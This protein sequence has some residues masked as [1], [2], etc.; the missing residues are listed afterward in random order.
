MKKHFLFAFAAIT[1]LLMTACSEDDIVKGQ[2]GNT[3]TF[4]VGVPQLTTRA[5]GEGDS[6]NKLYWGVYDH[7]NVLLTEI[8]NT[9][10]GQDFFQKGTVHLTLA[11]DK[12]YSIVFW[13][14]NE[15]N[16]MCSVDWNARKMS[17]EPQFANQESYDAF[18][19][20]VEIDNVSGY[21]KRDVTLY[22]P[23]AQ[24]NIG[25]ADVEKAKK[26][27]LTVKNTKVRISGLPKTYDF[28]TGNTDE[29]E[30]TFTY[31]CPKE[32]VSFEGE[33]F[34]VDGYEYLAMNYALL[35]ADKQLVE[36]TFSY[37]D[38]DNQQHNRTY[39]SVP[40]Q[41][42]WRTNI[43]GNILTSE[44]DFE[45]TIE[46]EFN[47]ESHNVEIVEVATAESLQETINEM[48]DGDSITIV[49]TDNIDLSDLFSSNNAP[50]KTRGG[51]AKSNSVT[52]AKGRTLELD[53]NGFTISGTDETE[54]NYGLIQNNGTLTI[55]DSKGKGRLFVE[56]TVNS[57]WNRYSA[58]ISNNPGATLTVN[59]GTIEHRG[60]T[61]MAY[62][63]DN[64]TNGNLG[65]VNCTINGGTI[66]STYRAV[67]QFLN[68]DSD[69]NNLVINGGVLTG[70][71]KSIFFQDPSAKA[72]NGKLIVGKNAKL[73]G[74]V[75]LYV[76]AGSTAWPVEVSIAKAAL[77]GESTVLSANVPYDYS[78]VE[79]DDAWT[80]ESYFTFGAFV[81][82]VV[83]AKGNFNGKGIEVRIK[84]ASGQTDN[85]NSCLVPNRLQK[86]SNPEVYYAQ[87]QRFAELTNISITNVNFV[88][89]PEEITVKDAWNPNGATT[90]KE[91][92]NGELQFMNQGN[93]TLAN[94]TF[95]KV[96]V[97]PINASAVTVCN[98]T[99]NGLQA[100]AIKDIKASEVNVI[101]NTFTDCNG[102]FWLA[103][104]PAKLVVTGNTFTGVGR[105]GAMQFSAN[106]DYTKTEMTVKDNTVE[107]AFLWQLN[108]T[109]SYAQLNAILNKDLN[110][111]TQDYTDNSIKHIAKVG[112]VGYF[113]LQEAVNAVEDGGTITL[114]A[115]ETFTE[116]NRYNN[117]GWWDGLGYN[118]DKS[119]TIDLGG[120]TISQNGALNDYLMWF[121]N[122]GAKPNTI[123]LKNGTLNAG[124]TAYCALATSSSNVQKI[125]INTENI[126]FINNNSNGA[127]LKIRG[128]SE[129]NVN[130]GTIIEGKNSYVGIEAVGN[131][132]VVNIYDN[133]KIYQKGT[134]SYVGAIVGA[135]YNA[136][137]NIYGGYGQSAK[138]GIIVMSTGATINVSGGEWIA[139]NDGTIVGDNQ[140]VLVSQNNRYESGWACKSVLNV[141]G[142]TFKGGYNCYG[143]GPGVEPDDAQINIKGGN[144]NAN[145]NQYVVDGKASVQNADGTWGIIDAATP[146]TESELKDALRENYELII[147]GDNITL[148][149]TVV[150]EGKNITIDLNGKTVTAE[151]TSAFTATK[152]ANL[153]LKNGTVTAYESVVRAIG[154]KVTV[155]SGEYT[156]TGTALDSPATYRYSIDSREGGEIVINGGTFKSNNGMINVGSTV[157]INGGKFENIVEKSMTRH[158]AYV[159]APL[160]INDGEFY[161]KA[162]SSAGGCFFCG[163]AAGGDIQVNGGKFTS[164]WT[165]GGVNRIFEVYFG[166]KINVTGGMFNTNGGIAT[167]VTENTDEA[168]KAAYPYVAK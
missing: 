91:N 70:K 22:R 131:N 34:P 144:F 32:A 62:G 124:T 54:A 105:R 150:I 33:T 138:C 98:S 84:P 69:E 31:D 13:A 75:Y 109:V 156:S 140:A 3:V 127:V 8:S 121:K 100:Y 7:N 117:G 51:E 44:A 151:L 162:N 128:G 114:I 129:L 37:I 165:S 153:T 85:T 63:I 81:D 1:A 89:I 90:T 126:T 42:N 132:T 83:A 164:L 27:G 147:L 18:C 15:T 20:Y 130:A 64:L 39:T 94:C 160:T 92:I 19:A 102:A 86:Y 120:F 133:A 47:K 73:N 111:Y 80:V 16:S 60:G 49:L 163:A 97:S 21:L 119:F 38:D 101:G 14:A 143:M 11:Q 79:G 52:L 154:G 145:P 6:A 17:V 136:T 55:N 65:N 159:S 93:V 74:D 116:N 161:G 146:K 137:M 2:G 87:Y 107:G 149:E 78:V 141:T 46:P 106:G 26:S 142:G 167:F 112:E 61:A 58:V 68:S 104:A 28:V 99:F 77:Q 158:F 41:R 25:T 9:A 110:T 166:G 57:G 152:G 36:V 115:D 59:G 45:V 48:E 76:T 23:F 24:L 135:S 35:S 157:T 71:N 95:D 155:E 12:K 134:S 125:T 139:N 56:A 122:D 168:T 148:T 66:K 30:G 29:C 113:T 103:D 82:T 40:M 108:K 96:A 43:Y 72:N 67:R 5:I 53:L 123:T 4:S 118:G 88:F 10:V 50:A